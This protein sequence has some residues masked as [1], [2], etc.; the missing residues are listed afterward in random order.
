MSDFFLQEPGLFSSERRHYIRSLFHSR[1]QSRYERWAALRDTQS[2]TSLGT[3]FVSHSS[4][5]VNGVTLATS[6]DS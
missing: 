6:D 3:G 2:A 1:A 4:W 5:C